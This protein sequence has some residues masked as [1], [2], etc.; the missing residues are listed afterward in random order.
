M[1]T[2]RKPAI[3]VLIALGV[4]VIALL[5]RLNYVQAG[6]AGVLVCFFSYI[7]LRARPWGTLIRVRAWAPSMVGLILV[8]LSLSLTLLL[9]LGVDRFIARPLLL[10]SN[11]AELIFAPHATQRYVSAEFSAL[12]TA[13]NLG[14]R[15]AP[16]EIRRTGRLRVVAIG[17]SFTF[18]YGVGDEETWPFHLEQNLK[19]AGLDVE[20]LNLGRPGAGPRGYEIIAADAIPLLKP[21]LVVL[22]ILQSEDLNSSYAGPLARGDLPLHWD[23]PLI[24]R[25]C[26]S[27]FPNLVALASRRS[28]NAR[29]EI[30]I[31]PPV[32]NSDAGTLENTWEKARAAQLMQAFSEQERARFEA[33]PEDVRHAFQE[34]MINPHNIELALRYPDTYSSS[35]LDPRGS[36]ELQFHCREMTR[37]LE[38]IAAIAT[39]NKAALIAVLVPHAAL[40]SPESMANSAR[41]GFTTDPK[42]L[43]RTQSET[44]VRENC[45]NAGIP[46]FGTLRD[47]RKA[48][49]LELLFYPMDQHFNP[50]GTEVFAKQIT[51]A[52]AACLRAIQ[53]ASQ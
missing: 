14:F 20:V 37:S 42:M 3:A 18:G 10:A 7:A 33:L 30:K 51:H 39:R 12:A 44:L 23:A 47:F 15:G 52:I 43:T 6:V 53:D 48:A 11:H 2:T 35:E 36:G 8:L 17:D 49:A 41:L 46:F 24:F 38:K 34:G 45:R 25:A 50:R 40:A 21:D 1:D 9:L 32:A 5:V 27:V 16:I 22:G 31:R 28:A 13:N 19:R 29:K 4:V 26:R